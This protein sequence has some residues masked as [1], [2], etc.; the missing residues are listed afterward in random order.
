MIEFSW[1]TNDSKNVDL[2]KKKIVS[3][4]GGKAIIKK[5]QPGWGGLIECENKCWV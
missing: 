2:I 1:N 4:K 5:K 3:I